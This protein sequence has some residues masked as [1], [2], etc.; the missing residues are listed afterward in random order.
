V[1][2][3]PAYQSLHAAVVALESF[4]HAHLGGLTATG[5]RVKELQAL[6]LTLSANLAAGS[7]SASSLSANAALAAATIENAVIAPPAKGKVIQPKQ[8][9]GG[10]K[11]D[12]AVGQLDAAI[13]SAGTKVDNSYAY[14][15][16]LDTRAGQS[17]L[18]AGNA[19][20]TTVE[21]GA[22]SYS[23]PAVDFNPQHMHYATVTG[24][25]ALALGSTLGLSLY[26][27]RRGQASSLF[28]AKG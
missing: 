16:A 13:T 10:A 25:V 3:A 4:A 17:Q 6:V 18:P 26:R 20:G 21:T 12:A 11:L 1:T 5:L 24:V 9:G 19:S 23:L 28:P 27:K 15:T 8:L 22:L 2:A 14:L 7:A